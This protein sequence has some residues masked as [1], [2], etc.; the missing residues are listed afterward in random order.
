MISE[1]YVMDNYSLRG[2]NI[3]GYC[4]IWDGVR[5]VINNIL[6]K[7]QGDRY[8]HLFAYFN[9]RNNVSLVIFDFKECKVYEYY[10]NELVR[11]NKEGKFEDIVITYQLRNDNF[12]DYRKLIKFFK[13]LPIVPF[14]DTYQSKFYFNIT[15]NNSKT[16][17][18]DYL[19]HPVVMDDDQIF[20]DGHHFQLEDH[21][22]FFRFIA[23][24]KGV[25]YETAYSIIKFDQ[26]NNIRVSYKNKDL[27]LID[28]NEENGN[29]PCDYNINYGTYLIIH[30]PEENQEKTILYLNQLYHVIKSM[31]L[32]GLD[33]GEEAIKT[34]LENRTPFLNWF[35]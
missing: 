27:E 12:E 29:V 17:L 28:K 6:E 13:E 22:S 10:C 3:T 4:S 23:T 26:F 21:L 8:A 18:V 14:I 33:D 19:D 11:K 24:T 31:I 15:L 32:K 34:Y 30:L 1:D 7:Y 25:I 9:Q 5:S 20:F 16:K 35:K 2:S